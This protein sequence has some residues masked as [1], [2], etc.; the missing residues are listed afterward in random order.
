MIMDKPDNLIEILFDILISLIPNQNLL[1]LHL[2]TPISLLNLQTTDHQ[3]N[4]MVRKILFVK[5]IWV[6]TD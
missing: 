1:I 3:R 6:I 4:T 2:V 5:C